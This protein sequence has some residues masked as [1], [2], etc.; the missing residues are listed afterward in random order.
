ME[1]K[2]SIILPCLNEELTIGDC[3]DSIKKIIKKDNLNAE[4]IVVDNG[5]IDKSQEIIKQKKVKLVKENKKGYGSAYLR[6]F[7]E[8]RGDYIF[9]AD[10]D[11]TYDFHE[12]PKF[13]NELKKGQDFVI[14]NRFSGNI[15]KN[16]MPW[17]HRYIGNPVLS[18]ILRFFFKTK[19]KDSHCGM[20]AITKKAFEKLNLKTTGMEFASEMVIKALKNKL[21]I[22]E[23][24]ISYHKRKGS[25]KL[26]SFSDGWR[27]LRFLLLHSP[28]YLFLFPGLF[29]IIFGILIMSLILLNKLILFGIQFQT[30]PMF[31]GSILVILGYQLILTGI[32][33][34]IYLHNYLKEKDKKL[35]KLFRFLSLE[36]SILIGF[37][38]SLTGVLI[39]LN[40]L[41]IWVNKNF[42]E[43]N[44]INISIFALTFIV[45]GIQTIFAGFFFSILGIE[46]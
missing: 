26:N 27:H 33:A 2:I 16:A 29:L 38:L 15:E 45:L 46:R 30:H 32:F 44:T 28:N 36:K 23:L 25:S 13:I 20:R 34:K 40:I 42:G 3:L 8:A 22:K 18:Q 35:E 14:G 19:I 21:K 12:I 7:K 37:I 41:I 10:S 6:G 17:S 24:P 39:Y 43:L 1:P 4:I 9:I 11:G 5:S 31:I